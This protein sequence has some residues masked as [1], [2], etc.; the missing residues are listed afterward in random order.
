MSRS[1]ARGRWGGPVGRAWAKK[2]VASPSRF[3]VIIGT[4]RYPNGA[5]GGVLHL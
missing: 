4:N 5:I 1:Q 3:Y 2:I